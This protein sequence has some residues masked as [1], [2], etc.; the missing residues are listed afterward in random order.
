MEHLNIWP[1]LGI[2][3]VAIIASTLILI[4]AWKASR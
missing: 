3:V 4:H 1:I 2:P